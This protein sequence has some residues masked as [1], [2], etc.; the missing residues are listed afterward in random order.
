MTDDIRESG[1]NDGIEDYYAEYYGNDAGYDPVLAEIDAFIGIGDLEDQVIQESQVTGRPL[2]ECAMKRGLNLND[3]KWWDNPKDLNDDTAIG[4]PDMIGQYDN[5]ISR[6]ARAVARCVQFPEST[7]MLHACGIIST[8]MVR[9]FFYVRFGSKK[10]VGLYTAAAQPAG[11]GKSPTNDYLVDPIAKKIIEINESNKPMM[12]AAAKDLARLKEEFAKNKVEMRDREL[13][14]RIITKENELAECSPYEYAYTDATPEALEEVAARQHGRFTI[15]TD[16]AE[17]VSVLV[18]A[19]YNKS[20]AMPNLG[21]MLKGW[22]GGQ[23]KSARIGRP[24]YSGRLYGAVA[25]LAQESTVAAILKTGRSENGSRGACE[26]FWLLDE[27]NIIDK[28]DHEKYTPIPR[29]VS[30][31]YAAMVE[32]IV[33][34]KFDVEFTF[35]KTSEDYLRSVIKSLHPHICDGGKWSDELMRGVISKADTQICKMASVLHVGKQF[36]PGGQRST[37]IQ[38]PEVMHATFM[39]MQMIKSFGAAAEQQNIG[40]EMPYLRAASQRMR[41]FIRDLKSPKSQIS[42]VDFCE[43]IK[44]RKPFFG[45]KNHRK[46]CKDKWIHLMIDARHVV[47]DAKNGIVFINPK[48]RTL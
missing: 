26:R 22:D 30:Q 47:F 20:G 39:Y 34:Q 44:N 10:P 4:R 6:M 35:S 42:F 46:Q 31:E 9:H 8:A 13:A 21:L 37:E 2:A 25:V 40:G 3:A 12:M 5:V 43:S 45:G 27:Q 1:A 15:V 7:S 18:G 32:S 19:N 17:G 14:D 29:E 36:V 41:E 38:M 23:Q 24:G 11:T 33:S 48:L 16:E 28:K